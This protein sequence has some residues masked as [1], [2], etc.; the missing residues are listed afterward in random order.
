MM[1]FMDR[2]AT[3]PRPLTYR[4]LVLLG[5]MA[6]NVNRFHTIT[7]M[8]LPADGPNERG[9]SP[10]GVDSSRQPWSTPQGMTSPKYAMFVSF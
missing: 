2:T 5:Y 1:S 3:Y 10:T 9:A 7:P 8:F 6:F 4:A